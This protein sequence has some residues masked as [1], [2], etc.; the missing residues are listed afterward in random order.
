MLEQ[1]SVAVTKNSSMQAKKHM[2]CKPFCWL[3][4]FK[5]L[6]MPSVLHET[7]FYQ[8]AYCIAHIRNFWPK[9]DKQCQFNE[10]SFNF[11]NG[12]IYFVRCM[13]INFTYL[14]LAPTPPLKAVQFLYDI[15]I[16]DVHVYLHNFS[17]DLCAKLN[18]MQ[19]LPS[20]RTHTIP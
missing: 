20:H 1:N 8:I 14:P 16:L 2:F 5:N 15:C 9:S 12:L 13:S 18:S 10:F 4:L 6:I 17:I 11:T 19:L 3:N 7:S